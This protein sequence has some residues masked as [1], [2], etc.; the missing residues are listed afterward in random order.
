MK[1]SIGEF[2]DGTWM[3]NYM[4]TWIINYITKLVLEKIYCETYMIEIYDGLK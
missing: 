3:I 1:T 2:Y 4:L